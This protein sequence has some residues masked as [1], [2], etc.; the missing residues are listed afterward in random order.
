MSEAEDWK[1]KLPE[2]IR[3]SSLLN[4]VDSEEKFWKRVQD[5]HSYQGMSIKIPG[6]DASEDA[7]KEFRNKLKEK[8]PSLLDLP[9]ESDDEGYNAVLARLGKPEKPEE[10]ALPE[11]DYSFTPEQAAHLREV[12]ATAGMTKRQFRNLAKKYAEN[13]GQQVAAFELEKKANDEAIRK[14]WGVA[15][16]EKYSKVVEFAKNSGAPAHFVK[17][18][19]ARSAK[20]DEV[21]FMA[22]LM[23]AGK[24]GAHI[25]GQDQ[26]AGGASG[27]LTPYEA[28]EKINE[29]LNNP[30]HPY[31]R[32]DRVAQKRYMELIE[33]ANA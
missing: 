12:A 22:K 5:Q 6:D 3:A 23:G 17:A 11:S 16:E 9:Q 20:A 18:L 1:T 26:P 19:E 7:K 31:H 30:A 15:A 21:L 14:E 33:M 8:V 25:G 32:G 27:K 4:G 29:I 24:E 10:Y 13:A 2:S 28:G